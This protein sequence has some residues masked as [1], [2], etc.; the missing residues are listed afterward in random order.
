MANIKKILTVDDVL[1]FEIDL[2]GYCN[3]SCPLCTRNY[4]HAQHLKRINHRPIQDIIKQLDVFPNLNRIMLAGA[5]SEPTTYKYFFELIDYLNSRNIFI[6]LFTNGSLHNREFWEK[7]G[8]MFN[9]GNPNSRVHFTV[10][11]SNQE[12][13]SKYRVGSE[14]SKILE[15]AESYRIGSNRTND[16]IQIIE[17]E[18][19]SIDIHSKQ[20]D[21]IAK[22]FSN[23]Y[24]IQ[25]EGIRRLVEYQVQ[26]DNDV[27][28]LPKRAN[29]IKTIFKF[30]PK[31]EDNKPIEIQCKANISRKL[32][33][34]Q[35]GQI[36]HCYILIEFPES[37]DDF[38]LNDPSTLTKDTL[39]D[40]TNVLNFKYPD[41]FQCSKNTKRLI[42]KSGLDFVC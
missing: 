35:F 29:A 19:N 38:L 32:F 41:C 34:N 12:M 42:E 30:R 15:N 1:E 11:G 17:F 27:A 21:D 39:F 3:L 2:T 16:Y 22:V 5:I 31:P 18:Y 6:D 20:M 10:C 36:H 14:L 24:I 37:K 40:F 13:H 28:P 9:Y 33:I 25:S 26:P 23:S 4:S 8:Y 7:L